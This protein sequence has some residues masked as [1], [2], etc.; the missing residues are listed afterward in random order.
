MKFLYPLGLWGLIGIPI[1]ILVYIIKN[2]YTE[3]TVSS[4]FLWKLSERFLKRRNPLSK[5]T[6]IISLILQLLLVAT[7]S[8]AVA[9]PIIVLPGAADEYCF[10]LDG[11]GSMGMQ[12]EGKTRFDLAKEE[13]LT[14]I[15]SAE[16][17]SV[18]SLL[19]VTDETETVFELED[20]RTV[21]R[22]RILQLQH[23]DG[24]IEYADA[25]G[26]A[27]GY[28]NE[29][30]SVVTYLVTDTDYTEH[31]NIELINVAR[32]ENNISLEDVTYSD[33]GGGMVAV[34]GN[35]ISYSADRTTDVQVLSDD[36]SE[37]L[38]AQTLDLI[39]DEKTAFTLTVAATD[40]YSLTVRLSAED[41]LAEDNTVTLYNVKSENAYKALLVSNTSFLLESAIR[42]V[43]IADLTVMT[44]EEYEQAEE[45][46][47]LQD[48]SVSGYGLYIYDAY[49]PKTIPVDGSVWLIG[50]TENV[51]SSGFSIQGEVELEKAGTLEL[52]KSTNSVM[53][54]LTNGLIGE[55]IGIKKYMKCGLYG[56]F[57]TIFSYMGNPVIFTGTTEAGNREVVFAFNL[58]D[59]DFTMKTDFLILLHNLLEYSFPAVIEKTA[60][61]CGD[62]AQINVISGCKSIRVEAPSGEAVYADT[63]YAIS[64][65]ALTEVGEY[66]II[67]DIAG[68]ERE[69]YI[70]SSLPKEE[71][72]TDLSVERSVSIR[73]DAADEG[74]DGMY[75][76]MLIL[77][78][79]AAVLFTAEWMVYCYDKYQ[80]R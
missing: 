62:N 49:N 51:E 3:Q 19:L 39:K 36:S 60:Y 43:S 13:I 25:I 72:C 15:D 12:S 55:D 31:L 46:L 68:T 45:E 27:Q 6:G 79:L 23:A 44:V 26:V 78:I 59:T 28:F 11:S 73:G 32:G 64:E 56:N 65:F 38:M 33:M 37:V 69:F 14:V 57:S 48:K 70:Y 21:I 50:P 74:R 54:K 17:G 22:E 76:P 30:A 4:T 40:F 42:T 34:T 77:L 5:I 47:A 16:N 41:A 1:L 7:L 75:D 9:H 66:K 24:S 53:K 58:H 2:R 61:D 10:I 35:V 20:D 63:S 80:F 52:K 8:L 67:V 18:F 71:R 29:N